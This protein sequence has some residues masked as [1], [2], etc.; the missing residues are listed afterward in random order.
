MKEIFVRIS[1]KYSDNES[2]INALWVEL[3]KKYSGRKRYYHNIDHIRWVYD[4]LLS[5]QHELSD[6]DAAAFAVFYHD[7]VYNVLKKDNEEQSAV[8]AER[9][10]RQIGFP[11]FRIGLCKKHI[12]ATK[13]HQSGNH[14]DTDFLLDADL[15]ILGADWETYLLYTQ[16]IRREYAV[17]PDL[18]YKPGRR[19]VI[20]HFL[21][22]SAIF[23]TDFFRRRFE[24]QAQNN[25][26]Q[27]L[28][29][30]QA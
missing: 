22:M 17:Y 11:D 2:L 28:E 26:K 9:R 29:I 4:L 12:L 14:P 6:W 20:E 7:A 16:K 24:V 23:K 3:E 10:L 30:L 5:V 21:G 8:L 15:S 27:E 1:E 18:I 13:T 19:K 25:L